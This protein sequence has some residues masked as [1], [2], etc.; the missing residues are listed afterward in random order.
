MG[1]LAEMATVSGRPKP[2]EHVRTLNIPDSE[3]LLSGGSVLVNFSIQKVRTKLKKKKLK[4]SCSCEKKY[5]FSANTFDQ[6]KARHSF[7]QHRVSLVK[8]RRINYDL[9]LQGHV[10]NLTLVMVKVK[11]MNSVA[12]QSICIVVMNT[13]KM[14]ISL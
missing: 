3:D 14:I 5:F 10:E 6:V 2:G 8:T 13:S 9:T 7:C 11:V 4:N 1:L 12:Y